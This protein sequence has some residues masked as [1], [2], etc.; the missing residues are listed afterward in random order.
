MTIL[1]KLSYKTNLYSSQ[2]YGDT[3]GL[4]LQLPR[5]VNAAATFGNQKV[6]FKK[7]PFS[8]N[9]VH[10]DKENEDQLQFQTFSKDFQLV[11]RW[12]DS[13]WNRTE[14]F[15]PLDQIDP[16]VDALLRLKYHLEGKMQLE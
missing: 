10:S 11:E 2:K 7:V 16:L 3:T 9:A 4:N 1:D 5:L 15:L 8:L 6:I 14:I 12:V 13:V